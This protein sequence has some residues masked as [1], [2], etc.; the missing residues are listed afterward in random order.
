MKKTINKYSTLLVCIVFAIIPMLLYAKNILAGEILFDGDGAAYFSFRN[1]FNTE[2]LTNGFPL[3]NKYFEAGMP[4]GAYDSAGLYPIA[5]LLSFLPIDVFSY[6]FYFVHL[7]FGALFLYLFIQEL[8]CNRFC[9]FIVAIIYETSIHLGGLRKGH[10]GLIIGF[11]YVPIILYHVQKYLNSEKHKWLIIS[12]IMMGLQFLGAHTQIAFYSDV[13]V[14]VYLLFGVL[15]KRFAVKKVI[16][17]MITWLLTYIGIIIAQLLS[18]VLFM[19]EFSNM[20]DSGKSFESFISYS[21]HPIKLLQMIFPFI[22]GEDVYQAYGAGNSSEMDIEIYLGILVFATV[23]FCVKKWHNTF[24]VRVS[25]LFMGI[26]LIYSAMAHIPYIADFLYLIPIINGFR[27][28]A[29][30]LFIFIFFAYV[31]FAYAF[32]KLGERGCFEEYIKFLGK[33]SKCMLGLIFVVGICVLFYLISN[34]SYSISSYSENFKRVFAVPI[35]ICILVCIFELIYNYIREE[36]KSNHLVVYIVFGVTVV[37]CTFIETKRFSLVTQSNSKDYFESGETS[38][39][40]NEIAS[41]NYKVLDAFQGVDGMHESLIGLNSAVDKEIMGINAYLTYNNPRLYQMLA[42]EKNVPLNYSGLMTGFYNLDEILYTKND[43]LSVLGVKYL[44][45]SSGLLTE[46]PFYANADNS[47]Q[48]TLVYEDIGG[49]LG[50]EGVSTLSR[51]IDLKPATIY[52]IEFDIECDSIPELL[53]F[54]IYKMHSFDGNNI[55]INYETGEKHSTVFYCTGAE[56]VYESTEIRLLAITQEYISISNLKVYEVGSLFSE[57]KDNESVIEEHEITIAANGSNLN[58]VSY[59]TKLDPYSKYLMY[60]NATSNRATD[61]FCLDLYAGDTYD[62]AEQQCEFIIGPMN[63]EQ[64][65]IVDSGNC[66]RQEVEFRIISQNVE[67][68]HIKEIRL[69]K[70][71]D[72]TKG[73]YIPYYRD[74]ETNIYINNNAKDILFAT[75]KVEVLS[76]EEK[77]YAD[78]L[79]YDLLDV[80]Y[81]REKINVDKLDGTTTNIMNIDF[82]SDRIGATVASDTD[83]FVNLSQCYN[84]GWKAYIDDEETEVYLVDDVIM[85]I[86]VPAGEHKIRFEFTMPI[87]WISVGISISVIIFWVVY[88]IFIDIRGKQQTEIKTTI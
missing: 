84:S 87:F 57:M 62:S 7:I 33:F 13:A 31:L 49:I 81:I 70:L 45:D 28:P 24:L 10:M 50:G 4:Y 69:I 80:T 64:F 44:I 11:V 58:V 54:D 15:E 20:G 3:W 52:K 82:D 35:V 29:R 48:H 88:F 79:Q 63:E 86:Y 5:L 78:V 26:V 25:V 75:Q 85:G 19:C 27:V 37:L 43:L 2:L 40:V 59:H 21:I 65:A 16:V 73:M 66:P 41:S 68:V 17:H 42:G 77:M 18:T 1:Y 60:I 12:A 32:S 36:R 39:I 71:D 61:Y 6:V 22:F 23:V 34:G 46:F 74:A 14:F 53:D 76:Q 56:D 38:E 72:T 55:S 51:M 8:G 67:D 30:A 9:A 47:M 83:T